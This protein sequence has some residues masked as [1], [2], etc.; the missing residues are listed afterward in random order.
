MSTDISWCL[1]Q[2]IEG[3][4]YNS[5]GF[6]LKHFVSTLSWPVLKYVRMLCLQVHQVRIILLQRV[7]SFV[8]TSITVA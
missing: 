4:G 1:I 8:A 3:Q 5:R 6:V 7:Q 2:F